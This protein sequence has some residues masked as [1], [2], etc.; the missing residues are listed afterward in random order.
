MSGRPAV[1][2]AA[3][4]VAIAAASC[5]ASFPAQP[6]TTAAASELAIRYPTTGTS[7]VAAATPAVAQGNPYF[8]TFFTLDLY[9]I[10]TDR[11]YSIV[12]DQAVW[13][14]SNDA[15]VRSNGPGR[16]RIGSAGTATLYAAYGGLVATLPVVVTEKSFPFLAIRRFEQSRGSVG[17]TAEAISSATSGP[18]VT[19]LATWSSSDE[20]I[21][22]VSQ[23][24]VELHAMGN[25]EIRATYNG[26]SD[27]YWISNP[28][29]R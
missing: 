16:M 20:R 27:S 26:M 6:T 5:T 19:T 13:T 17:L 4:G 28:P 24:H 2:L 15:V 21:A 3:L 23:G 9:A 29:P 1:C 25:V 8:T 7:L 10:D 14:S 11:V 18:V 22:T 12:T